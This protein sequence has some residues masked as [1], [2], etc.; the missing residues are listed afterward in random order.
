MIYPYTFTHNPL[1][2]SYYIV[3]TKSC[4]K[5]DRYKTRIK[6]MLIFNLFRFGVYI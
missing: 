1:T 3:Q 6:N 4:V 2:G 5:G